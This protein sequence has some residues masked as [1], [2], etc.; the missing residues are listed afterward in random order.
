MDEN[1]FKDKL[2]KYNEVKKEYE[3]VKLN[4]DY[5]PGEK[6]E[7]PVQT[8]WELKWVR[9]AMKGIIQPQQIEQNG[10][11][12]IMASRTPDG[13]VDVPEILAADVESGKLDPTLYSHE[14]LRMMAIERHEL[15][16]GSS[17]GL[18]YDETEKY[19]DSNL[20]HTL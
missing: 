14:Q 20:K 16:T 5:K 8:M 3:D 7:E 10:R 12:S 13:F 17:F 15:T 4:K 9:L 1:N 2:D 11:I 18:P 19:N 6:N